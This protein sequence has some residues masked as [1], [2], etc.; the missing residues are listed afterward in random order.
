MSLIRRSLMFISSST[1]QG[2]NIDDYVT[3]EALE[4]DFTV[5]LSRNATEYCIDGDGNWKTLAANTATPSINSGQ[6]ISIRASLSPTS[7]YGIGTFTLG[8]K[9]HVRG[10]AM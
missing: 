1:E 2:I 10:N 9:C 8:K 5:S 3:F 4:N 6:T 7:N